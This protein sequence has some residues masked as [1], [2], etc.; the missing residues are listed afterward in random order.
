MD[1]C[2][3][4][5]RFIGKCTLP[6]LP[7]SFNLMGKRRRAENVDERDF[8]QFCSKHLPR[9]FRSTGGLVSLDGAND[10]HGVGFRFNDDD[11]KS[12]YEVQIQKV[13]FDYLEFGRNFLY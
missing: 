7:W 6:I 2:M 8:P 4:D 11:N 10:Y 5:S 1:G 13:K 3:R 9:R 12:N